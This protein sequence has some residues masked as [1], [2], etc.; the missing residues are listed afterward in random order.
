VDNIQIDQ[1]ERVD[2]EVQDTEAISVTMIVAADADSTPIIEVPAEFVD[3]V[4]YIGLLKAQTDIPVGEY[5][6]QL[7]MYDEDDEYFNLTVDGCSSGDCTMAE[8]IVC[9]SLGENES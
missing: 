3:G 9:P 6:Y 5:V 1:G 8:F 7:R 4:A 2:I